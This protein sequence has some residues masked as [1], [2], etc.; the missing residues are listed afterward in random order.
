MDPELTKMAMEQMRH[1]TPEQ[2]AAMQQQVSSMSPETMAQAM[3]FVK[4]ANVDDLKRQMGQTKIPTD[5]SA[6][7][8]QMDAF[9][10]QTKAQAQYKFAASSNLK[11]EGNNLFASKQYAEAAEKYQR[12]IDNICSSTSSST[13]K[14]EARTL[15]H[16]CRLNHAA[17]CLHLNRLDACVTDCSEVLKD[18]A[19]SPSGISSNSR[20]KALYRRGQAY[21]RQAKHGPAVDDLRGAMAISP[22]DEGIATVLSKAEEALKA[23]ES[24]KPLVEELDDTSG[25]GDAVAAAEEVEERKASEKSSAGTSEQVESKAAEV[26]AAK[27]VADDDVTIE[28]ITEAPK[29]EP[30]NAPVPPVIPPSPMRPEWDA[31]KADQMAKMM[32]EN[33]DMLKQS[34]DMMKGMSDDDLEKMAELSGTKMDPKMMKAAADAMSKMTP[35]D[36]KSMSELASAGGGGDTVAKAAKATEVLSKMGPESLQQIGADMGLKMS[37]KQAK[38]VTTLV[39]FLSWLMR[40]FVQVR[41][42]VASKQFFAA[43]LLILIVAVLLKILGWV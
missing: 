7:K 12:A 5:P 25:N 30:V 2:L 27:A 29:V 11:Q 31:G 9:E 15:L 37:D 1:M 42:L 43:A 38:M 34:I 39:A 17:C 41:D 8:A 21:H 36:F 22:G 33:P 10:T 35:D 40:T 4:G 13:R 23:S 24:T 20:L 32:Q 26:S 3:N 19:A 18:G 14:D 16:A 28:E 6:M